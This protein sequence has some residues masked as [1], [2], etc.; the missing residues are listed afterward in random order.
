MVHGLARFVTSPWVTAWLLF[1]AMFFLMT[2]MSTPGVG[3]PG[4]LG[5]LCL[6]LFFWGQSCNGNVHW[7]EILLF[8]VGL[9]FVAL[10]VF[11]LPGTGVLGLGGVGMI[12]TAIVLATQTFII[13]RTREEF[14]RLPVSL[15][16][17]FAAIAGFVVALFLFRKYLSQMPVFKRLMLHSPG[18]DDSLR[19]I[20]QREALVNWDHLMGQAGRTVTPLVPA[21]KA[22]FGQEVIDVVSDGALI[23]PDQP[24]VV[25]RVSGNHVVVRLEDEQRS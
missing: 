10:E 9:A 21:G 8:V 1:G 22:K 12:F 7:L 16:M 23:E 18:S 4:F 24:I 19:D 6:L 13:P 17:V 25:I 5:T 2:E 11:V 14:S 15:S 3:L 20:D